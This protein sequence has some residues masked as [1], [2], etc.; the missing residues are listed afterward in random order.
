MKTVWNCCVKLFSGFLISFYQVE[1]AR[2]AT[3]G[4]QKTAIELSAWIRL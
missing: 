1:E 2:E 4:H 3:E